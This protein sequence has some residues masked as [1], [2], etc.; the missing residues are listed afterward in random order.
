[1]RR[2]YRQKGVEAFKDSIMRLRDVT[3]T[4]D[5]YALWKTHEVDDVS[6]EAVCPW[7]GGEHLLH[8]AVWLV[9]VSC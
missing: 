5:D 4:V 1:M 8:D 7:S 3:I 9:P 2:I 6:F